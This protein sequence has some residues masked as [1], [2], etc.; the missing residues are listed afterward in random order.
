MTEEKK[1]GATN[2]GAKR[3]TFTITP[4]VIAVLDTN[5]RRT[6]ENN[7]SAVRRAVLAMFGQDVDADR[8]HPTAEQEEQQP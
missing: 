8:P 7:S 1:R 4:D 5:K 2:I 6:G 3:V